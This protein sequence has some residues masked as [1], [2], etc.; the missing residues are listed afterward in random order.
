[1][2]QCI[3]LSSRFQ[4]SRA[5]DIALLLASPHSSI[6]STIVRQQDSQ[7]R[8]DIPD[9]DDPFPLDIERPSA[10]KPA[11]YVVLVTCRLAGFLMRLLQAWNRRSPQKHQSSRTEEKGSGTLDCFGA[12]R[13]TGWFPRWTAI[14]SASASSATVAETV[15]Q[16]RASSSS[17]AEYGTPDTTDYKRGSLGSSLQRSLPDS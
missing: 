17:F 12:S 2:F 10:R 5:T 4:A 3:R 14:A 11:G 15:H 6:F 9:L 16:T 13:W 1:M 7:H 8:A